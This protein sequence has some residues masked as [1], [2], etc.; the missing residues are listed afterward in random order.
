[1]RKYIHTAIILSIT[2]LISACEKNEFMELM[3]EKSAEVQAKESGE[4]VRNTTQETA[5]ILEDVRYW[6]P[7]E[8][9]HSAPGV[10]K[11]VSDGDDESDDDENTAS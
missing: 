9:D 7:I 3:D 8:S 2:V 1:M 6:K 10:V 4:N 11:E 5:P